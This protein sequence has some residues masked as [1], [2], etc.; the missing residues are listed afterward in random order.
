MEMKNES[1]KKEKYEAP[2]AIIELI[3]LE[4]DFLQDVGGASNT[5]P[6]EGGVDPWDGT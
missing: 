1:L 4:Q 5:L 3:K 2:E 6:G